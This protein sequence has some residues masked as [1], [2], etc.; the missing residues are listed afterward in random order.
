[1]SYTTDFS[2]FL[3]YL[4]GSDEKTAADI[5]F[6][7]LKNVKHVIN[8]T[9]RDTPIGLQCQ[10]NAN[11]IKCHW[12]R[13]QD[14]HKFDCRPVVVEIDQI[15]VDAI[16]QEDRGGLVLVH[17]RLGV[18]R[19]MACILYHLLKH[20][21]TEHK[22]TSAGSALNYIKKIRPIAYPNARF[23]YDLQFNMQIIKNKSSSVDDDDNRKIKDEILTS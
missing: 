3:P 13:M 14:N 7:K 17:C 8:V 20:H 9:S 18:S 1:M 22:L 21:A 6:L 11:G 4:A 2:L 15:I 19:S 23:M 5:N 10:Y 12:R 16:K